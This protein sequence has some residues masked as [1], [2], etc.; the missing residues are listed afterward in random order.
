LLV[1]IRSTVVA[2]SISESSF[3]KKERKERKKKERK[4]GKKE[5]WLKPLVFQTNTCGQ[6]SWEYRGQLYSPTLSIQQDVDS[7]PNDKCLITCWHCQSSIA[8]NFCGNV[9]CVLWYRSLM[10]A[11][12]AGWIPF[13][14]CSH[15]PSDTRC[16][17]WS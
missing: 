14:S 5:V 15:P 1:G 16:D 9:Q 11:W 2:P 12:Q 7:E 13:F 3:K 10:L 4:E 8:A 6:I 17:F